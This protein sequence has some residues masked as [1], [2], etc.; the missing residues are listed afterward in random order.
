MC[1]LEEPDDD[2]D[3]KNSVIKCWCGAEGTFDELFSDDVCGRRCGG[4]GH[5]DCYCGGDF[6]VCHYHG[7]TECDGCPDC[8][9]EDDDDDYYEDFDDDRYERDEPHS[10]DDQDDFGEGILDDIPF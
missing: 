5:V 2:F 6:C 9:G 7:G 1:D 10:R 4:S 3:P 8:E